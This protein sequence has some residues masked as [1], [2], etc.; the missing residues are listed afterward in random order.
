[1]SHYPEYL[2]E[3]FRTAKLTP[4]VLDPPRRL[5]RVGTDTSREFENRLRRE[6]TENFGESQVVG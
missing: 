5:A 2:D 3:F 1:V 6:W 4:T